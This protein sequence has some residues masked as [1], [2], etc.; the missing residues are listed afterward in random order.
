MHSKWVLL[1]MGDVQLR[2]LYVR[3]LRRRGHR[4]HT[5][6]DF[7]EAR[8]LIRSGELDLAILDEDLSDDGDSSIF[9]ALRADK[10]QLPLVLLRTPLSSD[11]AEDVVLRPDPPKGIDLTL[12]KPISPMEFGIQLDYLLGSSSESSPTLEEDSEVEREYDA[13]RQEFIFRLDEDLGQLNQ[14]WNRLCNDDESPQTHAVRL[15]RTVDPIRAAARQFGFIDLADELAELSSQLEPFL[16]PEA[17]VSKE[18]IERTGAL[19]QSLHQ[20]CQSL[21]CRRLAGSPGAE[22]RSQ[23]HILLVI[24]PDPDFLHQA[25]A[26]CERFMLRI[27]TA[28]D[29][30]EAL[31]RVCTP[32][33]TGVLLSISTTSNATA[34]NQGINELRNRSPLSPLPIA[35]VG[36]RG[37]DFDQIRSLWAGTSVLVSKPLTTSSFARVIRRLTTVRRAQKSSILIIDSNEEFAEFV[38]TH[39]ESRHTAV[40]YNASP[41]SLFESLERHRPDLLV[42]DAHLPGVSSFDICRALRAIPRWRAIPI[43]LVSDQSEP[44]I[45]IAAYEAGADDFFSRTIEADELRARISVRLERIRLLRER[46]DR[47]ALTGLL[48]RRAFL[49]QL[50]ARLS[51]ATRHQRHLTFAMLDIDHFKKVNDRYGHPAGDRVLARL[52]KQLRDCF[53]IE[54]LRCRWGGEEFVVVLIDEDIQTANQ[55]LQRVREQFSTISFKGPDEQKF[56]V[57]F[58]AGIAEFPRDGHDAETLLGTA[59]AR[60]LRAKESGRNRIVIGHR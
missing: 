55:A 25:E 17:M 13:L 32:L 51:E 37:E 18:M 53:R 36:E 60:L 6:S 21:Q 28:R 4:V 30:E 7:D 2:R 42:L 29:I 56:Q 23:T 41:T 10:P 34:L 3:L 8:R 24:D 45:R 16:R 27:R 40:H 35:L 31:R 39:L 50:A 54:D 19:L 57:T 5:T 15:R 47:D 1:F 33:L 9:A 58:S 12:Q 59:D 44:K 48:T 26:F 22:N 46:A 49:E 52:G 11:A 20:T 38:A 14:L 43:I